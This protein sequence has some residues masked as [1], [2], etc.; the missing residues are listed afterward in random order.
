[1]PFPQ[2]P[3]GLQKK[4][5]D[6]IS[7]LAAQLPAYQ[8]SYAAAHNGRMWQ[9]LKTPATHPTATQEKPHDKTRRPHDQAEDWGAL[10]LPLSAVCSLE[11]HAHNAAGAWGY[12]IYGTVEFA[13]RTWQKAQGV[14]TFD[15]RDM[16]AEGL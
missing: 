4:C 9:G 15:W 6:A 2:L 10:T 16:T 8:A 11:V 5:D 1:M 14:I 12:T 3:A 7:A 13:S